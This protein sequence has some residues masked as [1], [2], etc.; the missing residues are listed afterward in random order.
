M[1]ELKEENKRKLTKVVVD[2]LPFTEKG[3]QKIYW[4]S[5]LSGFG[6]R[7]TAGAKTYIV[8][9]RVDG[10]TVRASIGSSKK[11]T[12]EEAR[13]EAKAS[14]LSRGINVN[15]IKAEKK[16][17]AKVK[18][19][20]LGKLLDDYC[21]NKRP[22]LRP[23]TVKHYKGV[24][25]RCLTDWLDKPLSDITGDM[26]LKRHKEL[27]AHLGPRSGPGGAHVQA[28]EAMAMFGALWNFAVSAQEKVSDK[29]ILGKN[30]IRVFRQ[31]FDWQDKVRRQRVIHS[32][33]FKAWF[34]AVESLAVK[35]T[36]R[37]DRRVRDYLLFCLFT[38]LRRTEAAS[39]TW[40]NVNLDAKYLSIPPD[41][42]KNHQ[43]HRLPLSPFVH[44]LLT[45]RHESR[46]SEYV[47]PGQGRGKGGHLVEVHDSLVKVAEIS[48]IKFSLHDLR[49][50]FISIAEALDVSHYALK[51][52]A[53]HK[54]KN[55]VTAGYI[56][57]DV[58][59]LRQPMQLI[60]DFILREAGRIESPTGG[61]KSEEMTLVAS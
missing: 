42:T 50:T 1:A 11:W 47:F 19:Q 35:R 57:S 15:R 2:G 18:S 40:S 32:H 38:G 10:K 12:A 13:K 53:N 23:A 36:G 21:E 27:A 59:R 6:V 31:D 7:V 29:P 3:Q 33:E 4:D 55:D 58:E 48:G 49:R 16:A 54:S 46:T 34:D 41:L 37:I 52:L 5:E 17:E 20:T 51:R 30:P 61:A 26:L 25:K 60:T 39:L 56:A 24:I 9:A 22:K 43:E 28:D 14:D 45:E 8:Q 44:Q